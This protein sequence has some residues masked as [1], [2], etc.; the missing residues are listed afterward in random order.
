MNDCVSG[1]TE[2]KMQRNDSLSTWAAEWTGKVEARDGMNQET[3]RHS[4]FTTISDV[5]D[6]S[7]IVMRRNGQ[8]DRQ[9]VFVVPDKLGKVAEMEGARAVIW[10]ARS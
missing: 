2:R 6:K 1:A 10:K 8:T 4:P 9:C 5:H 3:T 7:V